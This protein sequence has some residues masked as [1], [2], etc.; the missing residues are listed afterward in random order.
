[1]SKIGI[2]PIKVLEGVTVNLVDGSIAISGPKGSLSIDY[3]DTINVELK[4]DVIYVNRRLESSRVKALHGLY[5]VLIYNAVYGVTNLWEKRLEIVGTGYNVKQQ[6][7]DL[8][9]KVGYSHLVTIK[10]TDDVSL[11]AEGNNKVVVSGIDK[12]KVGLMAHNIKMVRKPDPY[13]GKGVRYAGEI[14][15]LKPG[16]KAK[17]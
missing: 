11:K 7:E 8:V 1:M 16:K 17:A 2:K 6:G 15:K 3:P 5:R 9:F 14:I 13:K 4:D 12:Q 10:K